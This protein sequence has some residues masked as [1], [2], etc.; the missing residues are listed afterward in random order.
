[1][2]LFYGLMD[3]VPAP[4]AGSNSFSQRVEAPSINREKF[5]LSTTVTGNTALAE[6]VNHSAS[7]VQE[8]PSSPFQFVKTISTA[9]R[10]P[11]VEVDSL[12]DSFKFAVGVS[13][14]P[15]SKTKPHRR[16][17]GGAGNRGSTGV[18]ARD[19]EHIPRGIQEQVLLR[20]VLYALQ[21]IDS[22]NI[23]FDQ[24]ADQF[25]V[26][27]DD[28]IPS[29]TCHAVTFIGVATCRDL[30]TAL[31]LVLLNPAMRKLI[32][33]LCE[34][35]WLYRKISAYITFHRQDLAFGV[36]RLHLIRC[37]VVVF[38]LWSSIAVHVARSDKVSV[39]SSTLSW[40]TISA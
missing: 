2:M 38:E 37:G 8:Q 13:S 19:I 21:A 6:Q 3:S 4:L 9:A 1:M 12:E 28:A 23:Y 20:D 36:V 14:A 24:V 39:M 26:A 15:K 34:L 33:R 5:R 27:A 40:W 31:W 32:H 10:P 35:G 18:R 7:A 11:T 22:H 30:L 16:D 29:R 25:Q 17:G